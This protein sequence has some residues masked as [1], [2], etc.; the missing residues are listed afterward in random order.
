MTEYHLAN[1][2]VA[3]M[4]VSTIDDPAMAGFV[5]SLDEINA[6]AEAAPGFVWRLQTD[7]GHATAIRPYD[8]DDRILINLT[9]WESVDALRGY[10]YQS[11]HGEFVRRG[12]EWFEPAPGSSLVLW[13]IP[14]G[15]RPTIE[16]AVRRLDQLRS[17]GPSPEAFDFKDHRPPPA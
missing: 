6:I 2:N 4:R 15:E 17:E 7:E 16:D 9:V 3:R 10:V 5:E 8:D 14:A 11:R 1:F 12:F 13:W